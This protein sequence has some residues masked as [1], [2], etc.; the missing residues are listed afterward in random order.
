[1]NLFQL[2]PLVVQLILAAIPFLHSAVA[3]PN[4]LAFGRV[5]YGTHFAEMIEFTN[6]CAALWTVPHL[7]QLEMESSNWK[8]LHCPAA[9]PGEHVLQRLHCQMP[10]LIYV[11]RQGKN[12]H[13]ILTLSPSQDPLPARDSLPPQSWQRTQASGIGKPGCRLHKR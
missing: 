7:V 8:Y 5:N 10:L 9:V 11:Q 1:M 12:T 13:N 4:Q 2:P 3:L 6:R